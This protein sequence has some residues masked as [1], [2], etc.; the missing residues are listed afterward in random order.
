MPLSRQASLSYK[1]SQEPNRVAPNMQLRNLL[2]KGQSPAVTESAPGTP[3]STDSGTDLESQ[4]S[5][6]TVVVKQAHNNKPSLTFTASIE[7]YAKKADPTTWEPARFRKSQ[8]VRVQPG[9]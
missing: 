9:T 2:Q 1:S 7:D 8:Y 4:M 5:S 3:Y 6:G